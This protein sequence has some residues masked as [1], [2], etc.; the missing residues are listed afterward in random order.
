M[1]LLQNIQSM[2]QRAQQLHSSS[3]LL[4]NTCFIY[5]LCACLCPT[6]RCHLHAC[7]ATPSKSADLYTRRSRLA[8]TAFALPRYTVVYCCRFIPHASTPQINEWQL[9]PC[10]QIG[11]IKAMLQQQQEQVIT[12]CTAS[13]AE[14]RL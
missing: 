13:A 2:S 7:T 4:S 3:A 5:K 9:L 6:L 10:G 1:L 12:P 14:G 11:D 8:C